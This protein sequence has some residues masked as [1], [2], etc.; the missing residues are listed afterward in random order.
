MEHDRNRENLNNVR[1]W[2]G[3]GGTYRYPPL[4]GRN[5]ISSWKEPLRDPW[6]RAQ[7]IIGPRRKGPEGRGVD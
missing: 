5:P 4:E 3:G 6:G 2:G 1:H 7:M